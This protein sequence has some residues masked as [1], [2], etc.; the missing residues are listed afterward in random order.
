M[1]EIYVYTTDGLLVT[2]L[3]ADTRLAPFWPYPKQTPGMEISGLSFESEHFWPF[4]FGED[5]GNVY[6]A[7]GKW[8][9]SIVRLDG[10]ESV[11]RVDLGY[12]LATKEQLANA[13]SLREETSVRD[14]LRTEVEVHHVDNVVDPTPEKWPAKGWASIDAKSSFQLGTDGQNFIVVFRTDQPQLLRNSASEFPFA[15]TQ[16][17]GLDLMVRA[18]GDSNSR[19]V[20]PGDSRLFVT[21]RDGKLLA[22]LYRQKWPKP[23]N[24]VKFASPVGEVNFDDVEDVSDHVQLS[25]EAGNYVVTVPLALFGLDPAKGKV[26]RG[27]VG[28]VLSDG[29]RARARE[30]WHNKAD[31]MTAD[32]PSE[33]RLNPSQWGLFRF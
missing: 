3:G 2:T 1:G 25:A 30:Y 15:F 8:H 27:D 10:L 31:S 18:Q 6:L 14:K 7:V 12:V 28:M 23:G 26:Y 5:D 11:K 17:G 19:Q 16:G 13:E 4:M 22:V 9:A 20:G 24:A 21:R 32:V 29:T 33:A